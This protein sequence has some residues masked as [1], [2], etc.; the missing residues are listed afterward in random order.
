MKLYSHAAIK[1]INKQHG[2]RMSESLGQNFLVDESIIKK[3]VEESF[4]GENDL[5][6][7][8]GPGM[9][10]LTAEAAKYAKK[11]VAIEIDSKLIPILDQT[12]VDYDN[13]EILNKDILKTNL[14]NIIE[15]KKS[16]D[17]DIKDVKIIGNLPYYITTPI[18][19]KILQESV[20]AQSITVMTQKEVA[21]RICA[22]PGTKAYGAL[23]V[24]VQY[25]CNIFHVADVPRTDFIPQP[26]VDSSVLRLE[27]NEKKAVELLDEKMFFICLKAGFNQRRKTLLN[28]M[29]AFSSS[30]SQ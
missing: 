28:C 10:V 29:L 3:I 27:I 30:S 22:K 18:I 6:I 25:Y 16:E 13:I 7:E 24:A 14:R 5:V 17:S 23:T 4:I 26:K 15:N 2:F 21:D 1:E 19:M 11:V 9:G 20:P 8:I 12:L